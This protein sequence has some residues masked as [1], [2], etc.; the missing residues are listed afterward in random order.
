MYKKAK[1]NFKICCD[2]IEKN[3]QVWHTQAMIE[4]IKNINSIVIINSFRNK[5]KERT[6]N[7]SNIYFS[8]GDENLHHKL[9]EY[10]L[11]LIFD[12][13]IFYMINN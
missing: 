7:D 4:W 5:I 9:N 13:S 11:P 8:I 10:N 2:Y 1:E 6:N 12:N 3:R